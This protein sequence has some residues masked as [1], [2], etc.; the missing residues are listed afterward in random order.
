MA[1]KNTPI[2]YKSINFKCLRDRVSTTQT[3]HHG[4]IQRNHYSEVQIG[5]VLEARYQVMRLYIYVVKF[6]NTD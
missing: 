2:I 1:G 6:P 4:T 5:W 3:K